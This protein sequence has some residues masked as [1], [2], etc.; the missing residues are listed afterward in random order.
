[1][2]RNRRLKR[3]LVRQLVEDNLDLRRGGVRPRRRPRSRTLPARLVM[4]TLLPAGL[5]ASSYLVSSS[6]GSPVAVVRRGE[7]AASPARLA[8]TATP[9][10][11]AMQARLALDPAS[12]GPAAAEAAP[13]PTPAE[14]AARPAAAPP[15]SVAAAVF[16]LAVR[17]IVLDPG[18]G[19]DNLGTH[20]SAGLVEKDLTLDIALDLRDL[21]EH[22]GYEVVMTRQEDV[23]VPLAERAR[24]ANA[25]GADLFVSVHVNW[26]PDHAVRGVETYYLGPTDDPFLTELA[27]NENRDSGYAVADLRR[28]LDEIYVG[29]RQD[30][31]RRLA[32]AVQSSLYR[33]LH[34]VS[35]SLENRGVKSAPFLVLAKTEMPA[36]LA[37]VACLSN[38]QEA[39]LLEKKLYREYIAGALARGIESYA[40]TLENPTPSGKEALAP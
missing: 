8:A 2:A 5:L 16:P 24:F 7:P 14:V 28:L 15:P 18:H 12:G 29:V 31:S 11:A 40:E 34:K 37:E 39:A 25:E 9:T 3:R 20:P 21:L 35:P 26:I 17:K 6:V 38:E 32:E 19:G 1:V 10:A 27:A 22:D 30:T 23:A 36:I 33:W 13:G 4:L